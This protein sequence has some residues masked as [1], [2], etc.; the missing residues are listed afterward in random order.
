MVGDSESTFGKPRSTR[1][2]IPLASDTFD[3]RRK[4]SL[5]DDGPE[6]AKI[7]AQSKVDQSFDEVVTATGQLDALRYNGLLNPRGL[8][9]LRGVGK[10]Y[11]GLYYVKTV[12]HN[13]SK[14]R[15][16]QSF[17]LSREGTGTTTPFVLP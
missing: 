4:T 15:Y 17:S 2:I 1:S 11:D 9:G 12:T 13:I 6:R 7:L 10:T 14:G 3:A 5:I 8:V 16:I